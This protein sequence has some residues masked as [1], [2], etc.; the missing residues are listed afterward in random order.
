MFGESALEIDQ[1]MHIKDIA[2]RHIVPLDLR[3]N[4][5]TSSL[6]PS[7]ITVGLGT[8]LPSGSGFLENIE[9]SSSY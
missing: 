6:I 5:T 2:W 9:A 8:N 7:I 1:R 3:S 4:P